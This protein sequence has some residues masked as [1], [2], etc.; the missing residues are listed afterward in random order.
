MPYTN[1]VI[2]EVQRFGD[3]APLGLF[4][5]NKTDVE[6]EG[7]NIPKVGSKQLFK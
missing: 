1:A 6:F 2:N 4:H 3:I 5:G 7:Y